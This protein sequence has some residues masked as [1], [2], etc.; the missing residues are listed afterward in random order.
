MSKLKSWELTQREL[1]KLN[2][3]SQKK[4]SIAA[5]L[6]ES[7]YSNEWSRGYEILKGMGWREEERRSGHRIFKKLVK[8]NL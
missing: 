6:I 1:N 2:E 5:M 8:P 7:E 4:Y 3:E